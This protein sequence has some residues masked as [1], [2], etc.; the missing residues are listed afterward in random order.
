MLGPILFHI[1]LNDLLEVLKNYDI[2]NFVDD[3][4]ILVA[5]QNRDKL[6]EILKNKSESAVNWFRNVNVIVNSDK[7]QLMLLQ[8]PTKQ[9][10]QEKLQIDSNGVKSENLVALIATTPDNR[11]LFDVNISKLSKK[12]SIELKATFRLKKYMWQKELEVILNRFINSNFNYCSL[13]WHFN[14][15]KSFEK[16]MKI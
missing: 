1:F 12:A 14:T 10:I 16:K 15:N 6:L 9:I 7:Y 5:S 3:N 2:Y 4:T 13:V 8:E 11:L